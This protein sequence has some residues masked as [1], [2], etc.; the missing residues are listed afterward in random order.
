MKASRFL[1]TLARLSREL[2]QIPTLTPVVDPTEAPVAPGVLRQA[3][4]GV[5]AGLA[6]TGVAGQGLALLLI[7]VDVI[8]A[9]CLGA[10]A[11]ARVGLA[12]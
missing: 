9:A 10:A 7:R 5:L 12:G 3:P 4:V 6:G 8:A 2:D 11:G 1:Y